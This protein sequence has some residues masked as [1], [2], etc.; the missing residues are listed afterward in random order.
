MKVFIQKQ[1]N[2]VSPRGLSMDCLLNQC[3]LQCYPPLQICSAVGEENWLFSPGHALTCRSMRWWDECKGHNSMRG[4]I[5]PP[6]C[7]TA[8]CNK[9]RHWWQLHDQTPDYQSDSRRFSGPEGVVTSPHDRAIRAKRDGGLSFI[10]PWPL[11][12]PRWEIPFEYSIIWMWPAHS[13]TWL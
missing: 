13:R 3:P 2:L 12:Y 5:T 8:H 9:E 11:T 6:E 4:F 7:I 1:I 10:A